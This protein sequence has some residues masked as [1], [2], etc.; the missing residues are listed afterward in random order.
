MKSPGV[1]GLKTAI[2]STT[3]TRG[4]QERTKMK[5]ILKNLIV[6]RLTY[7]KPRFVLSL[8]KK[9]KLEPDDLDE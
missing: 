7:S 6:V 5:K 2:L 1:V 9:E 4:L 8:F 3:Q